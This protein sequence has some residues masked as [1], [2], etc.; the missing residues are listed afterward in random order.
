MKTWWPG[1]EL[2]RR[3][4]PFH[5][6]THSYLSRSKVHRSQFP[7][8]TALIHCSQNAPITADAVFASNNLH[9]TFGTR[10]RMSASFAIAPIRSSSVE[11]VLLTGSLRSFDPTVMRN[12]GGVR[13]LPDVDGSDSRGSGTAV[14]DLGFK[15]DFHIATAPIRRQP[16]RHF[17]DVMGIDQK[18]AGCHGSAARYPGRH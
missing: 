1:M 16:L 12:L 17:I 18:L 13:R 3:R 14:N 10:A 9:R 2:N 4:Q 6:F 8:K 11:E 7:S 5:D 15:Y